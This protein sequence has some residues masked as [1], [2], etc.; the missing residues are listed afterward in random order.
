MIDTSVV[1]RSKTSSLPEA[2]NKEVF[3]LE[4]SVEGKIIQKYDLGFRTRLDDVVKGLRVP[5]EGTYFLIEVGHAHLVGIAEFLIRQGVEPYFMIPGDAN[6][7][8]QETLRY[9][10]KEY[11]S[12]KSRLNLPKGFATLVD[13][14]RETIVEPEGEYYLTH[15]AFPSAK[16]LK[17]LGINRVFYMNEGRNKLEKPFGVYR[18][19]DLSRIINQ[20]ESEGLDFLQH[21]IW[22]IL[23]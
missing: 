11:E 14:H 5:Y 22:P 7:R 17:S 9:W 2:L 10:L 12:A 8:M 21:G 13:C 3:Q 18:S 4:D 23:P 19:P 16:K 15:L 20:Y 1:Y 6:S